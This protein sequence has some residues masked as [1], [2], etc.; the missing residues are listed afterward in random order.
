MQALRILLAPDE[1][2]ARAVAAAASADVDASAGSVLESVEIPSRFETR[3]EDPDQ[4]WLK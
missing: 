1:R 2:I 4:R 3:V